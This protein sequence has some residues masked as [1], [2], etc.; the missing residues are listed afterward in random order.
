MSHLGPFFNPPDFLDGEEGLNRHM[1][2]GHLLH[3]IAADGASSEY[4]QRVVNLVADLHLNGDD[5]CQELVH[6]SFFENMDHVS[7]ETVKQIRDLFSPAMRKIM[8]DAFV[9]LGYVYE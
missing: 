6:V 3:E 8:D 7:R 9:Q 2:L 1:Y 5:L 4:R